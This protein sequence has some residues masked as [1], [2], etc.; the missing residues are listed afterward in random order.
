MMADE[1]VNQDEYAKQVQAKYAQE[2][3]QKANVIG[4]GVGRA[5]EGDE[6][7]T[8]VAIVVMVEK[9]LPED[10]LNHDDILPRDI[11]G[12]RVDVQEVGTLDAQQA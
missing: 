3:M 8:E 2:L 5:R 11:E 7:T 9:K 12:V 4:V 6:P 1:P 10:Q